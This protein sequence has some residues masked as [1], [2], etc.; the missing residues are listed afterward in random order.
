MPQ[1]K[2]DALNI[3]SSVQLLHGGQLSELLGA[4][5]TVLP[6]TLNSIHTCVRNV[7]TDVHVEGNFYI[8]GWLA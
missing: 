3:G 8:Y 2:H 5:K 6:N 7:F 1:A 4:T